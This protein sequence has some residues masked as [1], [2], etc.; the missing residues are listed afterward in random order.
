VTQPIQA[1]DFGEDETA[2]LDDAQHFAPDAWAAP[3]N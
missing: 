3:Q 1:P 2:W